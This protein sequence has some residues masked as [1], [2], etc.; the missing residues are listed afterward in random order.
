MKQFFRFLTVGVF[1]TLLGYCVIFTCMY[2]AH[3]SPETSNV[4]GYAVGVV[5]SYILNRKYTFQSKQKRRNEIVRFLT[6][7]VIAYAANFAT[8]I[9]LIHRMGIRESTSQVLAGFIYVV[10][11]FIMNKHYAF[12]VFDASCSDA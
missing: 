7:F 10:A 3:M 1:N 5:A 8:L 11:S 6:A 2:L 4:A 12:K 9:I